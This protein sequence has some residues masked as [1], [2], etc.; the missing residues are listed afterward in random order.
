MSAPQENLHF[1]IFQ[2]PCKEIISTRKK[3]QKI[4]VVVLEGTTLTGEEKTAR[5]KMGR[6]NKSCAF[7]YEMKCVD[8]LRKEGYCAHRMYASKG[9]HSLDVIGTNLQWVRY[10]QVKSTKRN[11]VSLAAIEH[12]YA[13]DIQ[14]LREVP[15]NPRVRCELWIWIGKQKTAKELGYRK[16]GWRNFIVTG[17]QIGRAH[18]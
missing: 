5:Q 1:T 13:A 11:I 18:V 7:T 14:P 16:A 15:L 4:I 8:D 6:R 10:I 17:K 2:I 12:A 3:T 9:S